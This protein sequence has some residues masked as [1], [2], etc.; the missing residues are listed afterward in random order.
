MFELGQ[1]LGCPDLNA[2]VWPSWN[3]LGGAH[4]LPLLHPPDDASW[5]HAG[6]PH[7]EYMEQSFQG[8]SGI[9]NLP[10]PEPAE[11]AARRHAELTGPALEAWT[12]GE[13]SGF[14]S[15]AGLCAMGPSACPSLEL[16]RLTSWSSVFPD[17]KSELGPV[18]ADGRLR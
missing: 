13:L 9:L 17:P 1:K 2:R 8:L 14:W 16:C 5:L 7:N 4:L 3:Q 18:K 11:E 6:P 15:V 10:Q 12:D